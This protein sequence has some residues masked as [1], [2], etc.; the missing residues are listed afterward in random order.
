MSQKDPKVS[1]RLSSTPPQH[2]DK[3]R[4]RPPHIPHLVIALL[5]LPLMLNFYP[6]ALAAEGV[7]LRK[8]FQELLG[9]IPKMDHK[10]LEMTLG[11]EWTEVLFRT[12]LDPSAV[13]KADLKHIT[14]VLD[15]AAREKADILDLLTQQELSL[16]PGSAILLDAKLLQEID[17][18]YN[19][20]S[21][22]QINAQ[23]MEPPGHALPMRFMIVG[24]GILVIGYPHAAKVEVIDDGPAIEYHYEPITIA[25]IINESGRRGL[26]SVKTL[27]GR[28][29]DFSGF[30]GPMGAK[31]K[32]YEIN[33]DRIRVT[34]Q[35]VIDQETDVPRK[36]IELRRHENA[37]AH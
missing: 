25:R 2:T 28:N 8:S 10:G 9:S 1:A 32:G 35:L 14:A 24:Q 26:F 31:I 6:S 34:Y 13:L 23:T 19:L 17:A 3:T 29:D 27:S 37:A 21:V 5:I 12:E 4:L 30:Q 15:A 11:R 33:G 20:H 22:W 7:S 16:K 18:R 36:P